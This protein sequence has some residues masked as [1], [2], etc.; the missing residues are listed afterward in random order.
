MKKL[1]HTSIMILSLSALFSFY[2]SPVTAQ[3]VLFDFDNAPLHTSLPIDLT[4]SNVSAHFSANPSYYNYSIQRA[5]ALGFTPVGFA[6]YCIYPNTIYPCDLLIS[7]NPTLTAISIMYAPEEYATDSSCTMRITAYMGATIVGTNTYTIPEPGT[8]PTGTLSFSSMQPFDNVVIHYAAPP[9]TGGDYG[10]IFMA[11]NLVVTPAIIATPTPTPTP[12]SVTISGTIYY[13]SN[14]VLG[15][16]PN[17]TLDLT[18]DT[19]TATVSDAAGTYQFS[20]L[21][22]GGSYDVTP[23]KAARVP[24]SAGINTLDVVATQ[25]HFLVIGTPLSGCQLIAADVDGNTLVNTVDVIAIQRFFLGLS[26]GIAGTG[27][28]LFTPVSRTYFGIVNDQINQDYDALVF[29]D[30]VSPFAEP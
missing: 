9:V 11:D 14:P 25:R 16:V 29:G 10:P 18:G 4:V 26:I 30:V 5:D 7:F 13:C 1:H 15:P 23:R 22:V 20:S 24:G 21:A 12:G 28:Y 2:S 8:W 19:T 17:A 27:E 3:S 6:G